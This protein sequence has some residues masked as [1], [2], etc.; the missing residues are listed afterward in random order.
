MSTDPY[1]DSDMARRQSP[2]EREPVL[3]AVEA[4]MVPEAVQESDVDRRRKLLDIDTADEALDPEVAASDVAEKSK[5]MR[6]RGV[7][8]VRPTDLMARHSS[9]LAG[10]GLDLHT[11]LDA[12]LRGKVAAA[13]T[14]LGQQARR[15]SPLSSFGRG[16]RHEAPTRAAVGR[17]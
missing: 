13:R 16:A 12:E 3:P 1:N 7:E 6:A 5:L 11:R 2:P 14:A 15:L 4:V 17:A 10:R 8:W 9:A